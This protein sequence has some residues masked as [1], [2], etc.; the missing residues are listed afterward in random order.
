MNAYHPYIKFIHIHKQLIFQYVHINDLS[1][2][3][4]AQNQVDKLEVVLRCLIFNYVLQRNLSDLV[5][6]YFKT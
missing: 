5:L 4:P 6:N 1:N 3:F 2:S